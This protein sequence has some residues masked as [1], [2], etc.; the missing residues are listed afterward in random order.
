[1]SVPCVREYLKQFGRDGSILEF[2]VSSATVALAAEALKT[3]KSRIAK[4]L[5]FYGE[6]KNG[7]LLIV[8]AGDRKIDNGKFKRQFGFKAQMPGYEEVEALTGHPA[9]GVCPFANPAGVNAF[10]DV[11]LKRFSTVFP[12]AGSS[13]SAIEVTCG[14]LF[15]YAG[16]KGW[17]DVCKPIEETAE[18]S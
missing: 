5:S 3:D 16:A 11:S 9:G 15:L 4:T 14:Q 8:T 6:R 13:N 10:L 18:Q 2:S 1:M 7:C 12:A 17:V